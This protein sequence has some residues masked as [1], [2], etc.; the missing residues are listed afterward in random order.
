MAADYDRYRPAPPPQA[1]DWLIPPGARAI[2][3]AI[4]KRWPWVKHLF[5]DRGKLVDK[6]VL[7]D[8]VIEIVRS[9]DA[10]PC[11][12]LLPGR[13]VVERTF[14]SMNR[15]RRLVRDHEHRIDVSEAV[16][17]VAIGSLLLRRISH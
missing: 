16:I 8:F 5:A 12:K 10:E 14:G 3:D 15:W 7:L 11:F 6:A 1:L 2:L 17:H 4:R 9:I 13:W